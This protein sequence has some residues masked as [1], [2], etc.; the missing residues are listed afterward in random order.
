MKSFVVMILCLLSAAP[1]FAA[2]D[3]P[4]NDL[5]ANDQVSQRAAQ[6]KLA[7]LSAKMPLRFEENVGQ[8]KDA[9]VRY[10]ARGKGY[11]ISLSS[12]EAVFSL[13]EAKSEK[14]TVRL[15]LAGA[16]ERPA[17][18][19]IDPLPTKSNYLQG[20]DPRA[21]H[22]G[23]PSFAGVRYEEVYP[24][25]DLIFAGNAGNDRRVEQ[26]FFLEAG[27][28]PRRIRLIYEGAVA[29]EIGK[30]GELILRT[31][32][33]ELTAERPV[34]YQVAGGERRTVE[35][36]YELLAKGA[37]APVVGFAL[38]DYDRELPLVID[39]VFSNGMTPLQG[40]GDDIGHAIGVDGAGNV[41]VAGSTASTDFIGTIAPG[42]VQASNGGDFDGF[43]AKIDPSGTTLLYSTYLGGN[44]VDEMEGIAVDAAGNA[45]VTG[46]TLSA[47]FTVTA[48][49][50]QGSSAGGREGFV[51]KLGPAGSTL[52]YS[53]Y[54]GGAGNDFAKSIAIDASGN[55]YVAGTT[56]SSTF[57][58][59]TAGSLQPS[60]AG[61][62]SDAFVTKLDATGGATVYSTYLG[63][64]DEEQANH[65]A[66]DAAGNAVIAGSTCSA[67]FPVTAGVIE[68][69]GPG[70]DCGSFIYDSF[71]TKLNAAGT[72]L[73]YSTFLGGEGNDVAQDLA[74]DAAGNAYVTGFTDSDT[75][76]GVTGGSFQPTHAGGYAA[77]L[78]RLNASA[79]AAGYS[80]FLG[81]GGSFGYGIAVDSAANAY[82]TGVT[83]EGYPAV[84]ADTLIP[85]HGG[86]YAGFVT[87]ADS[88]GAIL[89]ST[90]LAGQNGAGYAVAVDSAPKTVFVT[91]ARDGDGGGD[92]FL[93]RIAPS[94]V[95]SIAKT[96]DVEIVNP[97]DKI[98]Y[99][100]TYRNYGELDAAG[101]ALTETVPENTVFKPLSS[102]PGWSCT[103]N[104]EAGATC[105]L[106][107]GTVVA[108][109]GGAATFTV[110]VKAKVSAAG[111]LIINRACAEPGPPN[112]GFAYTPTTAAPVLSITK[113]ARFNEAKPGNVLRYTIKVF[114][115]GNQDGRVAI[116]DTVP[117]NTVFDPAT[118]TAGWSCDPNGS[119]GSVCTY[120]VANLAAGSHVTVDFAVVL[121]TLFSNTACAGV[122]TASPE[123]E[124]GNLSPKARKTLAVPVCSTATTPLK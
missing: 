7:E 76:T 120:E 57:P 17:L 59:V 48:G 58:G 6:A 63:A 56:D 41:Y 92:A 110:K 24:G 52:L 116:T 67:A 35:C 102:T 9:G 37:E 100:L 45:Y 46:Y 25:T 124:P 111:S 72:A 12:R 97:G 40:S 123:R 33:G 98:T 23:V 80:T 2:N 69:A 106:A 11:W 54:L 60:N 117:G 28:E 53:T 13:G 118:S 26:S 3:L 81:G 5:P 84:N 68:P 112:C 70:L 8:V 121:S 77:F 115:A 65:V 14:R 79:T 27:A 94:A 85:A 16:A 113:T 91:G 1:L 96:A 34:A 99:T 95:L 29:A 47:N 83:A 62:A 42:G 19:G 74:L 93:I 108:G 22:T 61:G 10:F 4:A 44:G 119:A 73:I 18:T 55:A 114:N 87:K 66:V 49:A 38:G 39:P 31:P 89:Y 32:G 109:A 71:V 122:I 43:V 20:N 78:T 82:V 86:G 21:W 30:E 104:E 105:T 64:G 101:A 75:F 90:F 103:P 36:R 50:L 88:T 51:A 107:L 15:R